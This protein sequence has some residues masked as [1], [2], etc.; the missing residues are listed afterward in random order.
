MER[1]GAPSSGFTGMGK[2]KTG[3]FAKNAIHK[4][5]M[6]QHWQRKIA[7]AQTGSRSES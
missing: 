2:F 5:L 1:A 7:E 4:C 6:P 3:F